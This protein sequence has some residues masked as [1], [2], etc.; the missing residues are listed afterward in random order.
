MARVENDQELLAEMIRL[1]LDSSPSLLA[2]IEA[3]VT[4]QD[5]QT[6]ERAAHG[7]KG[8]L[9]SISA[10]PASRA[11]AVL[12]ELGRAGNIA[13]ANESLECLQHEYDRLV[14]VLAD[15]AVGEPT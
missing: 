5:R 11:A 1:F 14:E 12:E 6:I 2:E 3:G 4:R 15:A 10:I 9:Q 13:G 8:A 7:F